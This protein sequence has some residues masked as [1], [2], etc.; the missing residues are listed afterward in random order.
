MVWCLAVSLNFNA[1]HVLIFI[2]FFKEKM[3]RIVIWHTFG[4]KKYFL[5]LSHLYHRLLTPD[6]G[7][8]EISL[9]FNIFG[10]INIKGYY[11][12]AL[13][14]HFSHFAPSFNA[15][16]LLSQLFFLIISYCSRTRVWLTL[17]EWVTV[18]IGRTIKK[19]RS[20][21]WVLNSESKR[22]FPYLNWGGWVN[23]TSS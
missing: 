14:A 11:L 8:Q 2:E 22:K 17:S 13:P 1:N 16:I 6:E 12:L 19:R 21:C 5:R 15:F 7:F 10:I 9:G 23:C 18:C 3:L 4:G 20:G